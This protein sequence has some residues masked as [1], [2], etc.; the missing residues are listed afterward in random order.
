M[1]AANAIRRSE[2]ERRLQTSLS[3][4]RGLHRGIGLENQLDSGLRGRAA[5]SIFL[6]DRKALDR[7]R[8]PV[9][10]VDHQDLAKFG[11]VIGVEFRA[12]GKHPVLHI[13]SDSLDGLPDRFRKLSEFCLAGD[14]K[15]G[16]VKVVGETEVFL[17]FLKISSINEV[18]RGLKAVDGARLDAGVDVLEFQ[19]NRIDAIGLE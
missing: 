14:E 7:K 9:A 1:Q 3:M 17:N 13:E 12:L 11:D 5:R 10:L 2:G 16:R 8:K 4:M 19:G 18:Q 6:V 15:A